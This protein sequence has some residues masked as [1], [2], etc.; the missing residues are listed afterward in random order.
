MYDPL[1]VCGRLLRIDEIDL[2]LQDEHFL[3]FMISIAARWSDVY[4]NDKQATSLSC[5]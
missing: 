4:H 3:S 1:R 5:D 2:V